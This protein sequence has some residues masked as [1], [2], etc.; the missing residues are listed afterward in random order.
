MNGTR[1]RAVPVRLSIAFARRPVAV[2]AHPTQVTFVSVLSLSAMP[3]SAK[4]PRPA[5]RTTLP[6]EPVANSDV[7]LQAAPVV[8]PPAIIAMGLQLWGARLLLYAGSLS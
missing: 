8:A 6:P 7:V 4:R 3:M 5:P 1:R 2:A